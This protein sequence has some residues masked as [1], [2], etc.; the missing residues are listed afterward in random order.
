[1]NKRLIFA[2]AIAAVAALPADHAN[3]G[4]WY[5]RVT[6]EAASPQDILSIVRYMGYQPT[7]QVVRRGPYYVVH[8]YDPGGVEM[9][10]IADAQFGDILS[11]EPALV[12]DQI[13][14][15]H[16]NRGPLI[17]HIPQDTHHQHQR[18]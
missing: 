11:V 16:Y 14:P 5:E 12:L 13:Y 10:V 6:G 4:Q 18:G 9:R 3:A 15:P 2:L 1:V 7:T 17:I 8:A